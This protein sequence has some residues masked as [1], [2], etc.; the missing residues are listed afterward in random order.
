MVSANQLNNIVC[1]SKVPEF[2]TCD[3][4]GRIFIWNNIF[5]N[6]PNKCYYHW[7]TLPVRTLSLT[8]DGTKILSGGSECVLVKTDHS[9]FKVKEFVTRLSAPICHLSLSEKGDYAAMVTDDNGVHIVDVET[10]H[11]TKEIRR[12]P[13]SSNSLRHLHFDIRTKA[14][15]FNSYVG[16]LVFY[17]PYRQSDLFDVSFF[18]KLFQ[19]RYFRENFT[20]NVIFPIENVFFLYFSFEIFPFSVKYLFYFHSWI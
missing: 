7:H 1:H 9:N 13:R 16:H 3:S 4:L 11:V 12:L 17:D 15:V 10:M 6:T 2:L 20:R 8:K 19:Y 5:S 18:L 14:L